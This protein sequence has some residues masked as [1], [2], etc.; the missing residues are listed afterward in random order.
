MTKV[1][2]LGEGHRGG[3][4]CPRPQV[5]GCVKALRSRGLPQPARGQQLQGL[6][7]IPWRYAGK[8]AQHLCGLQDMTVLRSQVFRGDP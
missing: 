2:P 5:S 1:I 8:W 4:E 6:R 3:R 7:V